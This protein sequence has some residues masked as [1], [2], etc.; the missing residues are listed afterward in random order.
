[1]A[2]IKYVVKRM[3]EQPEDLQKF[4]IDDFGPLLDKYWKTYGEEL[5]GKPINFE[6]S[7]FIHGW[8]SQAAF[9]LIAYE[10]EKAV[11]FVIGMK[12]RPIFY[13]AH[14]LQL[15]RW[16]ADRDDVVTGMFEYINNILDILGTDEVYV[17]EF[18]HG[19]K[20]NGEISGGVSP[21]TIQRIVR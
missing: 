17:T 18:S 19:Q 14:I 11:G 16:Y 13:Q 21:F 3:P 20:Y 5:Y 10:N 8:L 15:E 2:K 7:T 6:M 9:L 4:I 12:F 1:M